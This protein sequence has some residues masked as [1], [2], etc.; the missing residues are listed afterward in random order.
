V[1][2]SH[3]SCED[4]IVESTGRM[5]LIMREVMIGIVGSGATLSMQVL[6]SQAETRELPNG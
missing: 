5:H 3:H 2:V 1:G 6:G 4:G